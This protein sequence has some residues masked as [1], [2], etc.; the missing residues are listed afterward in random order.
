MVFITINLNPKYQIDETFTI[1]RSDGEELDLVFNKQGF[2]NIELYGR[3]Y[4]V[5]PKWLYAISSKKITMPAGY[6]RYLI[7]LMVY[8]TVNNK[9]TLFWLNLIQEVGKDR[10][11]I[12]DNPNFSIDKRGN[13]FDIVKKKFVPIIMPTKTSLIRYPYVTLRNKQYMLHRLLAKVFVK[14]TN[15]TECYVVDHIDG[16]KCNYRLDNL[17]W[18]TPKQN[19]NYT[20]GQGL[21]TDNKPVL[22]RNIETGEVKEFESTTKACEYIGRSRHNSKH[23]PLRKDLYHKGTNGYYE[24]KYVDDKRDW[25]YPKIDD[26][27]KLKLDNITYYKVTLPNG[28]IVQGNKN[29]VNLALFGENFLGTTEAI[30]QRI[31]DKIPGAEVTVYDRPYIQSKNVVTGEVL[32]AP[33]VVKL[34]ELIK[35][36]KLSKSTV[37]KYIH[38]QKEYNGYLFRFK[39]REEQDWINLGSNTDY[40]SRNQSVKVYDVTIGTTTVYKSLREAA[41][42]LN[43]ERSSIKH[44][45]NNGKV[46]R[47]QYQFSLVMQ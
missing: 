33:T 27:A 42:A 45:L 43:A 28:K 39:P 23:I 18:C 31:K 35:D 44:Y 26:I 3:H 5:Q 2:V 37:T 25:N 4:W 10:Y 32:E 17:R 41:K 6:E 20:Y 21:K 36:V 46:F 19:S 1:R 7:R 40:V 9:L 15:P 24:M 8:L 13:V 38:N 30:S 14:N 29:E 47:R 34:I 16:N 22:I 12:P 11:L